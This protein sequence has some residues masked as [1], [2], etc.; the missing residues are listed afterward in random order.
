M[1]IT[2]IHFTTLVG[3]VLLPFYNKLETEVLE[4]ITN[5]WKKHKLRE[6]YG[7]NLVFWLYIMQTSRT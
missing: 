4:M 3:D 6:L 2:S 5:L 1:Y 7:A